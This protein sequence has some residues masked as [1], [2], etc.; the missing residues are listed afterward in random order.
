MIVAFVK[1]RGLLQNHICNLLGSLVE[2][3]FKLL[4]PDR[5]V[6]AGFDEKLVEVI[7]KIEDITFGMQF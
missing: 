3:I 1:F 6:R 4:Y 5:E 7:G 2:R